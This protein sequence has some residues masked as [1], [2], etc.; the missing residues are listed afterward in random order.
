MG[1][2]IDVELFG[3]ATGSFSP[4]STL[5]ATT[6]TDTTQVMQYSNLDQTP[7][8]SGT[9]YQ[10][11]EGS[12]S[13]NGNG[14]V[15]ILR[16]ARTFASTF[17]TATI[18]DL[19]SQG[20]QIANIG[21]GTNNIMLLQG[22][23][24]FS[25]SNNIFVGTAEGIVNIGGGANV[26][27]IAS[28][29]DVAVYDLNQS[30]PGQV[31]VIIGNKKIPLD[32]GLM[33]VLTQQNTDDFEQVKGPSRRIGYRRMTELSINKTTRAFTGDFSIPSAMNVAEP[34][35][36]MMKSTEKMDQLAIQ[37]ILKT[38]TVLSDLTSGAGPFKNGDMMR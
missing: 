23:V 31:T 25:P 1:L 21:I 22:T 26:L 20:V 2:A 35:Q 13:E 27:M 37:K 7:Q 38:S 10:S 3:V 17:D 32:P 24:V 30:S 11:E 6:A 34:L 15:S 33:V 8:E 29:T 4:T 5:P 28:G 16:G 19:T 14:D 12:G 36:R 9:A 18:N